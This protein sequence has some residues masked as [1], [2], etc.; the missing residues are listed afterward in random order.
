MPQSVTTSI[1]EGQVFTSVEEKLI[2]LGLDPTAA[3][4]E[5][6]NAS[7]TIR[8]CQSLF[9]GRV[10]VVRRLSLSIFTSWRTASR[11]LLPKAQLKELH[12]TRPVSAQ[13]ESTGFGAPV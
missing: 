8:C 7:Q 4:G 1:T 11:L 12:A 13:S 9:A 2:R 6:A 10:Q 3:P 5:I